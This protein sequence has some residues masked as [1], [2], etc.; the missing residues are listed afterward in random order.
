MMKMSLGSSI[1]VLQMQSV[2]GARPW[3]AY[4][5]KCHRLTTT[6][7]MD[8]FAAAAAFLPIAARAALKNVN[9]EDEKV[10]ILRE[11]RSAETQQILI[12]Y[13]KECCNADQHSFRKAF[14]TGLVEAKTSFCRNKGYVPSG[15]GVMIPTNTI[16][17]ALMDPD[18]LAASIR[19]Q[20]QR[21][22]TGRCSTFEQ[23]TRALNKANRMR[24]EVEQRLSH[25]AA[26]LNNSFHKGKLIVPEFLRSCVIVEEIRRENLN[27]LPAIFEEGVMT[28]V[29]TI[30]SPT[31]R[32][33][34]IRDL[35]RTCLLEY[36]LMA[37]GVSREISLAHSSSSSS[38]F[39]R[40]IDALQNAGDYKWRVS[41]A[42]VA[43]FKWKLDPDRAPN[44]SDKVLAD[45]VSQLLVPLFDKFDVNMSDVGRVVSLAKA[46]PVNGELF[47]IFMHTMTEDAS[48]SRLEKL[49]KQKVIPELVSLIQHEDAS[50]F[51]GGRK[52]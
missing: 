6:L 15:D 17:E 40:S 23:D 2:S 36:S 3:E 34:V 12:K 48:I 33:L 44:L 29:E 22:W 4:Y 43:L 10:E 24:D 41:E 50:R 26:V 37:L 52:K 1:A 45:K 35:M 27:M 42:P 28:A 7:E 21:G 31:P 11:L 18:S 20:V 14:L 38:I 39:C 25:V 5:D 46:K 51:F 9:S 13:A 16:V 8:S 19:L 49:L 32:N 47:D 30:Q